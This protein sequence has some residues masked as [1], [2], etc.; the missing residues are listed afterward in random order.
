MVVQKLLAAAKAGDTA[1]LRKSL[2]NGA[3]VNATDNNGATALYHASSMGQMRTRL[4]CMLA[5]LISSSFCLRAELSP[6]R[7]WLL[8]PIMGID[9]SSTCYCGEA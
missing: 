2:A 1:Q 6:L 8:Q 4:S 9:P 5:A 3:D 7:E